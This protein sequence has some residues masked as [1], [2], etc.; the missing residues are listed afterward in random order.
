VIALY[1]AV[2]AWGLAVTWY[3]YRALVRIKN[4]GE[5]MNEYDAIFQSAATEEEMAGFAALPKNAGTS[6]VPVAAVPTVVVG[7][8]R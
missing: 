4:W 1:V 3:G 6:A 5:K 8:H 2:S 7:A